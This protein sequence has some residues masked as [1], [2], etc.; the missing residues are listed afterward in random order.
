MT[1]ELWHRWHYD[2]QPDARPGHGVPDVGDI[3]RGARN[4]WC[5]LE[6]RPVDSRK[7]PNAWR[8]RVEALGPHNGGA[9]NARWQYQRNTYSERP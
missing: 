5:V 4:H 3:I 7:H 2:D 9:R 1:R 6:V 8:G